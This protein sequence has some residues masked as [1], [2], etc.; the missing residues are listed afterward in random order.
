[1][2]E[3]SEVPYLSAKQVAQLKK[4]NINTVID[5]LYSFPSRFEDYTIVAFDDVLDVTKVVTIAG[6]VQSKATVMN[7][8]TSLT[9]MNF[10]ADIDGNVIKITIFNR[11]FLKTKIHY[12]KYVRLTGKF[13]SSKKRFT[14]SEIAF[15]EFDN[16]ITPV[17][18]LKGI[19]DKKI[20]ELKERIY[21]DYSDE[22]KEELPS[23]I[24]HKY[25][26]I[27]IKD[28]IRNINIPEEMNDTVKA[29]RRIKFEELLKYQLKVRYMFYKRRNSPEGMKIEY[30]KEK[31]QA[32]IDGL[33]FKLTVD[34][35][36]A[37]ND[38]LGD[39]SSTYKM[40]RLLQGEVGSGK[41]VVA[42]IALYAVVTSG[43]QGAIMV[44]T[45]VLSFQH[46]KT[47]KD[48]FDKMTN[49]VKV[50]LL[51][52]SVLPKEKKEILDGLANGSIDIVVGTHSL[53]QKDVIFHRLGLV[54]TDEEH[55][56]GVKQRVSM[57][58]KGYLIDHLK[59]SATPIPRTLAI[60]LLGESDISIIKTLPGNRKEVITKYLKRTNMQDVIKHLKEQ[61]ALG[62]QAYII[63]PTIEQSETLDLDNALQVFED[64]KETFKGIAKVGLIHGKLKTEEKEDVMK[65]FYDNGIQILVATSVIEVGVNVVNATTILILDADR[66]GIAQLHQMRGRV[67]RS[68]NQ[69]YCFLISDSEVETSIK[70]MKLVESTND[71]FKLAEEDLLIRGPGEI[72]GEKQTGNQMF[73]M[74]DIVVDS[75]IL[76]EANNC[77]NEMIDSKALF[78]DEE[79]KV[80]YDMA[81][82]NYQAKKEII[83]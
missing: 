44:P 34:Q 41:T 20:L 15:D 2:T 22:I 13:D 73:K 57:V 46:Y 39:I 63:T 76:E 21:E 10:Y 80:L 30:D 11:Q 38:I 3:L 28:A 9:M 59:M 60:S 58:G 64:I 35:N 53:I 52:S 51:T 75:D 14:A 7:L 72:F 50:A 32:F 47:F 18:N 29:I 23:Y 61:I 62:H 5:L 54:V 45:E 43:Y 74:A 16:P 36:K 66:F 78:D 19:D 26:L 17:F 42:A 6:I 79:Y 49:N 68:D 67:R 65:K 4:N 1:M 27:N 71:G 77:A 33:P 56:F 70:R 37:L 55:R 24:R 82:A 31:V 81:E 8:K 12:G 83:E 25:N 48:F 40:N 69:A